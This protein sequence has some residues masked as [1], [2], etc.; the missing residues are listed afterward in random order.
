MRA[1]RRL[2]PWLVLGLAAAALLASTALRPPR[3][4]QARAVA[5]L[6][7]EF[8]PTLA[9]RLAPHGGAGGRALVIDLSGPGRVA[10]RPQ[11]EARLAALAAAAP[12]G[13]QMPLHLSLAWNVEDGALRVRG[14]IR[15]LRLETFVEERYPLGP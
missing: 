15:T 7:R 3:D 1:R 12:A 14:S 2:I 13:E 9:A 5:A 8:L 6:E 4:S 11:L 10:F